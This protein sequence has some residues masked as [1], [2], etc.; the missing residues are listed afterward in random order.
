MS[1][2]LDGKIKHEKIALSNLKE[3][4]KDKKNLLYGFYGTKKK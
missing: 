2:G 1:E 3:S 4:D